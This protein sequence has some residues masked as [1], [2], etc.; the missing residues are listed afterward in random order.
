MVRRKMT[1]FVAALFVMACLVA[2]IYIFGFT[3]G[4]V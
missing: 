1:A 3:P 2:G 4:E